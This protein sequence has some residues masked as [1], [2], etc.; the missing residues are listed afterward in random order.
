[1]G[2]WKNQFLF[3]V[4]NDW[5]L[6]RFNLFTGVFDVEIELKQLKQ[7]QEMIRGIYGIGPG[8]V[9]LKLLRLSEGYTLNFIDIGRNKIVFESDKSSQIIALEDCSLT[10]DGRVIIEARFKGDL[11][12]SL[13][14]I[15]MI[16]EGN[17]QPASFEIVKLVNIKGWSQM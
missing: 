2:A 3:I 1:M 11:G 5:K 17:D 8:L 9:C 13:G 6:I 16:E 14:E 12:Y 10:Y 15:I 7:A 4:T